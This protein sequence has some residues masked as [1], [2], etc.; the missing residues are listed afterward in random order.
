MT[1]NKA[2]RIASHVVSAPVRVSRT[3]YLVYGPYRD[4]DPYG[5][6]TG[7]NTDSYPRAVALRARWVA[8]ISL[9]L[10]GRSDA[11][12]WIG[13]DVGC[14]AEQVRRAMARACS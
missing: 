10:M 14:A 7:I 1:R 4:D 8:R 13:A 6:R 11:A 5:R 9:H 3:S 12:D 2:L